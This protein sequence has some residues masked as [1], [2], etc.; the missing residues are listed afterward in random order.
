MEYNPRQVFIR[1]F[2]SD[3]GLAAR[4]QIEKEEASLL[5]L[6]NEQTRALQR[7]L[8]PRDR[9]VLDSHLT[10]VREA[11]QRLSSSQQSTQTIE[12]V[13]GNS[14]L[15]PIPS[16]VQ[17]D[18]DK[19]VRLMFDLIAIAY[20]ADL[21][22][23]VSFIM[24]AEGTN[25]V[26]S[27]IGVPESFHPLSH[28]ANDLGRI[29]QLVKIQTWHVEQFA[30][31]LG[32]LAA[33]P[34]GEGTLLDNAM[35]LYGSNMSNSD[36]HDTHPLPTLLIGGGAGKLAGGRHIA[37]PTPTPISNLHLSLLDK[38]GIE[39]RTFG[40]STGTIDL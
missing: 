9:A 11:E 25:R 4:K 7:D 22:R 13:V 17:D 21:T 8:D 12:R 16:G 34:D 2:G 26:Y 5:D 28:H 37:L 29:V 27:H 23:V 40:D 31:F 24:A 33:I 39:Q 3:Q 18:F 1:L 38:V 19:Q 20:R 30:E 32:R 15:P 10:A 35:F 6:I 36:R 14:G